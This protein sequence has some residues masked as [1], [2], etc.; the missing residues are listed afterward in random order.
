MRKAFTMVELVFVIV[1]IGILSGIAISKMSATRDDA[2]I[3]KAKSTVASIRSAIS[4]EVQRRIMEGNYTAIKNVGGTVV[5]PGTLTGYNEPIFKYYDTPS[6]GSDPT[7]KIRVL[8]YPP[9]S[10]KD[11]SSTG[12]WIRSGATMYI[13]YAPGGVGG[14]V[15]FNVSNNRFDCDGLSTNNTQQKKD[16]CRMLDR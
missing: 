14:N 5:V 12:C 6:N 13:Y 1:V 16:L 3:T 9:Y 7:I 15:D 11:A 2:T 4:S 8:E 10:C